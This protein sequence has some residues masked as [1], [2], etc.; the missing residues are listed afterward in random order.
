[1]QTQTSQSKQT[2]SSD[3]CIV[4][5]GAVG[6]AA[7]LGFARAGLR[8]ILLGPDGSPHG[9]SKPAYPSAAQQA[10]HGP[11]GEA[12]DV[13]VFALNRVAHDLLTSLQV[14]DAL[15]LS[16]VTPVSAMHVQDSS[17]VVQINAEMA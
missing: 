1:M 15:D 16:R 5:N 13:R 6:K 7:A 8:V 11:E 9:T 2:Y 14:W 12:W 10:A 17:A 3:I 4:G